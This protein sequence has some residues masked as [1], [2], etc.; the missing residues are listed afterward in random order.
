MNCRHCGRVIIE[1][2]GTWVDPEAIGDDAVW[3]ETC[4]SHDTFVAEHEPQLVRVVCQNSLIPGSRRGI[5]TPFRHT[6]R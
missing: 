4:D 5:S 1:E 6:Y 3:S 2:H